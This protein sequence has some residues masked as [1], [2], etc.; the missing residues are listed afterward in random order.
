MKLT[1]TWLGAALACAVALPAAAAPY[2]TPREGDW[3]AHDFKFHDGTVMQE[4]RLHYTRIG[5]PI[6]E[7]P[8]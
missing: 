2:P 1:G 6:G 8:R 7:P 5:N 3:I 4:L